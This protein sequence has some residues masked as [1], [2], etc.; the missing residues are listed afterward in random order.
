MII[1]FPARLRDEASEACS[2]LRLQL[3]TEQ[4]EKE[5]T[6]REQLELEKVAVTIIK[7]STSLLNLMSCSR[8]V[9]QSVC[10]LVFH[11]CM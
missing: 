7:S 2:K 4:E 5:K 6:L 8:S 1:L 10:Q 11:T 3:E 9:C